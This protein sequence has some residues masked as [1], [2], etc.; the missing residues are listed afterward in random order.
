MI[1]GARSK[2]ESIAELRMG[3]PS[4]SERSVAIDRDR[5]HAVPPRC[6]A[7]FAGGLAVSAHSLSIKTDMAISGPIGKINAAKLRA[8]SN[9][10]TWRTYLP[11]E[12]VT[13][14]IDDGWHWST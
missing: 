13:A 4:K 14:M 3:S 7:A 6:R 10:A 12:C 8:S 1:T 5:H 2:R 9:V 11:E